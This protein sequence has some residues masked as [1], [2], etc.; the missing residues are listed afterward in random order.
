MVEL[1]ATTACW[2][3]QPTTRPPWSP[4][5]AIGVSQQTKPQRPMPRPQLVANPVQRHPRT[6][7]T[8]HPAPPARVP[9]GQ[10]KKGGVRKLLPRPADA[11]RRAGHAVRAPVSPS[12]C[13]PGGTPPGAPAW[14]PTGSAVLAPVLYSARTKHLRLACRACALAPCG[15]S[16]KRPHRA[17]APPLRLLPCPQQ[18]KGRPLIP[19]R[20]A[21]A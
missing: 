19:A 17:R 14:Q 16:A 20:K 18:V 4:I 13:R 5:V 3:Q 8:P 9:S 11:R 7:R 6:R 15:P 1:L 2:L 12:V 10:A 21:P